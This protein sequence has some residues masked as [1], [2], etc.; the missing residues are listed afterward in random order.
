LSLFPFACHLLPSS[1]TIDLVVEEKHNSS[2]ERKFEQTFGSASLSAVVRKKYATCTPSTV[3]LRW[4]LRLKVN[5]VN[6]SMSS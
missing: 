6:K 5:T 3:G 4:M 2:V 1:V